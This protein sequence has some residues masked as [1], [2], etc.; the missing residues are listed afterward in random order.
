VTEDAPALWDA[1]VGMGGEGIIVKRISLYGPGV[2]AGV[3]QA[4]AEVLPRRGRDRRILAAD[5]VGRHWDEAVMLELRYTHPRT[6]ADV[7]IR[8][9]VRVPRDLPFD[10][11]GERGRAGLA[12]YRREL[13]TPLAPV[14]AELEVRRLDLR[15]DGGL[16]RPS[17]FRG[18]RDPFVSTSVRGGGGDPAYEQTERRL[19]A[20]PKIV[21]P[22]VVP[23]GHDNG[24][25]PVALSG[26]RASAFVGH[27]ER[28]V[29]PH[30]G[31]NISQAAPRELAEAVSS[32]I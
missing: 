26:G 22:T 1:W 30:V 2:L 23:H 18:R 8:Q 11:H 4:E 20:R 6:G 27:S 15:A 28:R 13:C 12:Q 32:L 5:P 29:V 24:V 16:V 9:A 10:F 31:Y 19:A 7:E 3:A 17:G 25:S 14:V 21:A